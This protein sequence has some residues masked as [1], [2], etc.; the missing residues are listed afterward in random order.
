MPS[1]SSRR[2]KASPLWQVPV[3]R[4]ASP[5][6]T[7]QLPSLGVWLAPNADAPRA[8]WQSLLGPL[9]RL[10]VY[11][12]EFV[13]YR[14]AT[15]ALSIRPTSGKPTSPTLQSATSRTLTPTRAICGFLLATCRQV[16]QTRIGW[17]TSDLSLPS[18]QCH[19]PRFT[20][21]S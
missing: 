15:W 4:L 20:G 13:R 12:R 9:A 17:L 21:C 19:C 11:P 10:S 2:S 7:D 14:S 16:L 5:R 1:P 3:P 6:L 18:V 8:E